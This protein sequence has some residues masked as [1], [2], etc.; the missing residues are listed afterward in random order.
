[1]HPVSSLRKIDRSEISGIV[2][3]HL[4]VL[5]E[6]FAIPGTLHKLIKRRET[7]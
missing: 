3:V 4:L 6:A 7:I 2:D 1:M 5:F